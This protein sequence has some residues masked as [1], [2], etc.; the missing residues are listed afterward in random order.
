LIKITTTSIA[1]GLIVIK[2]G[3]KVLQVGANL[4]C[5]NHVLASFGTS[6]PQ[7]WIGVGQSMKSTRF[8]RPLVQVEAM[9]SILVDI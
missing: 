6:L 9:I 5:W 8:F 1:H 3:Q 2:C 4:E 7:G